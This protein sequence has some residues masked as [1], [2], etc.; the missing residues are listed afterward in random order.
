VPLPSVQRYFGHL[1]PTMAMRYIQISHH[2]QQG[3]FL[4]FKKITADGREL[5][6]ETRVRRDYSGG[7]G[8]T[9]PESASGHGRRGSRTPLSGGPLPRR[10]RYARRLGL[11]IQNE[12]GKVNDDGR[13]GPLSGRR[14][15]S[16]AGDRV[17]AI[18]LADDEV[19]ELSL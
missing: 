8:A 9:A 14:D 4:R 16:C 19:R 2:T 3:E 1:S 17:C 5:E 13:S 11:R 10:G 12:G 6:L 7:G 18:T 15:S